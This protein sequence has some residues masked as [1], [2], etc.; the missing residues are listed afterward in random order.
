MN[1]F[2]NLFWVEA[3]KEFSL[4]TFGTEFLKLSKI[5]R[6]EDCFI[7]YISNSSVSVDSDSYLIKVKWFKTLQEALLYKGKLKTE[8][9]RFVNN[10]VANKIKEKKEA[11]KIN[12]RL[13]REI[14][15][16]KAKDFKLKTA[17]SLFNLCPELALLD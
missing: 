6:R 10:Y 14:K 12:K 4:K 17:N 7:I 15:K 5:K 3:H 16:A 1:Y 2:K 13:K 8:R 9:Q 11:N